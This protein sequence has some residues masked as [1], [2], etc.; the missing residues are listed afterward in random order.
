MGGFWN[1]DRAALQQKAQRHL[2]SRFT[3]SFSDS[4]EYRV[5]K[6]I[7]SPFGKGTP[8]HDLRVVLFQI[9]PRGFLLLEHMHLHLIDRWRDLGKMGQIQ[10]A[11]WIKVGNADSSHCSCPPGLF[12]RAVAAIIIPKRLMDQQQINIIGAQL[13]QRSRN[14]RFSFF[15]TGIADPNFCGKKQFFPVQTA[16]F[17]RTPHASLIPVSLRRINA[18]VTNLHRL[19][20]AACCFFQRR[21][22]YAVA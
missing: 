21:L 8:G 11:V 9:S 15:I 3:V 13:F 16:F 6:I 18:A 17:Q 19:K 5:T 2:C 22:V 10:I 1:D 7:V 12:H 20:H 4:I 14:G